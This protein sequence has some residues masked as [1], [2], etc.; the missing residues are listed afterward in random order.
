MTWHFANC[1]ITACYY[2]TLLTYIQS[3][4]R[5]T[6]LVKEIFSANCAE[7]RVLHENLLRPIRLIR[8]PKQIRLVN[9]TSNH[10]SSVLSFIKKE[11]DFSAIETKRLTHVNTVTSWYKLFKIQSGGWQWWCKS[12]LGN[13]GMNSPSKTWLKLRKQT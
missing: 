7:K 10:T 11:F 5:Y 4:P 13:D 6:L 1:W 9:V 8:I 3:L 12:C 2:D